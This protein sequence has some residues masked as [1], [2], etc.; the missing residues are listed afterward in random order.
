MYVVG[1][2][3]TVTAL[4]SFAWSDFNKIIFFSLAFAAANYEE[5][6]N[7]MHS[8]Q[9]DRVAAEGLLYNKSPTAD[10]AHLREAMYELEDMLGEILPYGC[11]F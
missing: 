10:V 1:I 11:K 3:L 8:F 4:T 6:N 5:I 9:Q 7:S 2:L